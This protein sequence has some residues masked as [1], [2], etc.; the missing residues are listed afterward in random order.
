MPRMDGF[1]S[2]FYIATGRTP[3]TILFLHAIIFICRSRYAIFQQS[4]LSLP[5][6]QLVLWFF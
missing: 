4:M 2:R 5:R 1:F 3:S 6:L